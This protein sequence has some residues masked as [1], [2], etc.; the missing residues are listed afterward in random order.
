MDASAMRPGQ[1]IQ[2]MPVFIPG[3][4]REKLRFAES[5]SQSFRFLVEDY[6]F[7]VTEIKSTFVRYEK[8][9]LFVKV[10]HGRGSYEMGV[11]IGHRVEHEGQIVEEEFQIWEVIKL[12]HDL[13]DAGYGSYATND[14]TVIARFAEELAGFVCLYAVPMLEGDSEMFLRLR[15]EQALEGKKWRENMQAQRLRQQAEEAFKKR[16]YA[17]TEQAYSEILREL[18]TIQLKASEL[19][20]LEIARR[21]LGQRED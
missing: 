11:E 16:D 8:D 12:D 9:D 18:D 10:F 7:K 19:K 3:P 6:G 2:R 4:E 17:A 13:K 5:V 20:R 1:F 14:A 21:H 15:K